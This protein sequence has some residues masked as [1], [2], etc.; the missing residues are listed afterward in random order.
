MKTFWQWVEA[1]IDNQGFWTGQGGAGA[2]GILAIAQDTSR[3]CLA[4]RSAATHS[5]VGGKTVHVECWGT[6]G[7]AVD[8]GDPLSSA[9]HEVWEESGFKGPYIKTA[10]GYVFKSASF[11]Y[12]NYIA[13]VPT[14]FPF[15]PQSGSHWE[16]ESLQWADY[17]KVINASSFGGHPMHDG[18]VDL[19]KNSATIIKE[20]VDEVRQIQMRVNRPPSAKQPKVQQ[21][22]LP[23]MEPDV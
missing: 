10:Q 21:R 13:L 15:K 8:G 5:R 18:L 20:Y 2:S 23:G 9:K 6:I 16:T 14:E 1:Q 11:T 12:V 22:F 19:L 17:E 3:I 7:G 4:L